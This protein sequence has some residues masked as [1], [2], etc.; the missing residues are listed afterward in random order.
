MNLCFNILV[1]WF[2][3]A[4]VK[5]AQCGANIGI[6]CELC[7][8]FPIFFFYQRR[9]QGNFVIKKKIKAVKCNKKNK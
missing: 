7:K 8:L 9:F 5:H 1:H 6:I 4:S 3:S 2:A